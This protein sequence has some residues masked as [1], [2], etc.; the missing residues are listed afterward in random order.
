[1]HH[2]YENPRLH[3]YVICN[4]H[5]DGVNTFHVLYFEHFIILFRRANQND[6]SSQK[7]FMTRVDLFCFCQVDRK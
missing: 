5:L 4:M 2:F 3:V 7:Y 1:M 6:N